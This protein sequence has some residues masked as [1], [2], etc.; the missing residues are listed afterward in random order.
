MYFT[1]QVIHY[2]YASVPSIHWIYYFVIFLTLDLK[3]EEIKNAAKGV[4]LFGGKGTS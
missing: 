2:V 4:L 1:S 3:E